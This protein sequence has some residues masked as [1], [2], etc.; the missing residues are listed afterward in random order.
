MSAIPKYLFPPTP[1]EAALEKALSDAENVNTQLRDARESVTG[2]EIRAEELF[3]LISLLTAALPME[4]RSL[5]A[6]RAGALR[7]PTHQARGSATFENVVELFAK[8]E[9]REWSAP[10]V[11]QALIAR[12]T[13]ATDPDQV[14]NVLHY[15]ARKG[16]LKRIS[17]GRYVIIGYGVGIEGD[18]E[19]GYE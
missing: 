13:P 10:E 3:R 9:R 16:R 5:Y 18:P 15:L 19:G 12:G 14:S 2:L 7:R 17:R 4:R 6:E 11:Q 1:Y 8:D